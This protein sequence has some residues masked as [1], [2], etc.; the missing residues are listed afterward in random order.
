MLTEPVA[1]DPAVAALLNER[2]IETEIVPT[3]LGRPSAFDPGAARCAP[4]PRNAIR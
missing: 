4:V 3:E 1:A 2:G